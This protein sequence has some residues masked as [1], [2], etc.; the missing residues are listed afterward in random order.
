M[1][2]IYIKDM[3][4]CPDMDFTYIV[5]EGFYNSIKDLL[6]TS[7][8]NEQIFLFANLVSVTILNGARA[9]P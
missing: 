9:C 2:I 1:H 5:P 6:R 8:L 7:V 4:V 3:S